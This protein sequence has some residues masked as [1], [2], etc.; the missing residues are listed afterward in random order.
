MLESHI[1]D[2]SIMKSLKDLGLSDKLSKIY[3]AA[4]ENGESNVSYLAQKSGIKRT[5]IYEFIDELVEDGFLFKTQSG[6]KTLYGA[7]SPRHIIKLRRRAL[8]RVEDEISHLEARKYSAFD[9]PKIRFFY[10]TTGFK[11]IWE[12]ILQTSKKEYR[13]ITNGAMFQRYVTD[14]YLFDEIIQTKKKKGIV[15]KQLIVNSSLAKRIMSKDKDE[16]RVSRLL[17]P[18]TQLEFTEVITDT[19]TA[20]VS[21]PE[22]NF[23]FIV[24]SKAFTHFR[25]QMFDVIWDGV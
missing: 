17:P 13:I 24:E 16:N 1:M 12:E 9:V 7:I 23:Q 3:L 4:L 18:D 22:H 6:K 21:E 20:F 19:L 25:R 10:G 8:E 2:V 15:S 14:N 5:T 11:N